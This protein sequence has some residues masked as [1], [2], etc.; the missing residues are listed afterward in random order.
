MV[1]VC[2]GCGEDLGPHEA[3]LRCDGCGRT[4][5]V[6]LGIPDLRPDV[7]GP[8]AEADRRLATEL[9][10]ATRHAEFE[11]L[12][13]MLWSTHAEVDA[14]AAE[15]FVLGDL[16]AAQR[17]G[18][19]VGQIFDSLGRSRQRESV[20]EI[21]CG[22]GALG[23]ALAAR[24]EQVVASDVSLSWLV[25]ARHRAALAGLD[26]MRFVTGSAERLPFRAETF[27]LVVGSDVVE[28]VPDAAALAASAYRVLR[29]GGALWLSTPNRYSL[30]PEPHV[31]LWGVGYLPRRFARAYVRRFRGISYDGI[32]PLSWRALAH[33]LAATGGSDVAVVAP[34]IVKPFRSNYGRLG[35][36]LV[37]AYNLVRALPVGERIL[38][39]VA[40]LFHASVRRPSG[41]P[42]GTGGGDFPRRSEQLRDDGG[43]QADQQEVERNAVTDTGCRQSCDQG[44]GQIQDQQGVVD[45]HSA[46][47][48]PQK[49]AAECK[50]DEK[51]VGHG[52]HNFLRE[53]RLRFGS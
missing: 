40:P 36:V 17:S 34:R 24:S 6:V 27:D 49:D 11:D 29:P 23:A 33:V 35:R 50:K 25:L 47:L 8:G 42:P 14:S 38:R 3:G 9:Q 31:G 19:V 44:T 2:I 12:L 13:R 32:R 10:E 4:F 46:D 37:D 15:K 5:E 26:N 16:S 30:T 51:P 7:S 22:T 20:L 39:P 53:R 1:L 43:A 45:L 41:T 48:L 18:R 21:G 28:H 52:Q